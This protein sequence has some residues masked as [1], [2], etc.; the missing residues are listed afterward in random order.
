M[1]KMNWERPQAVPLPE[2]R[3]IYQRMS[4]PGVCR[5][6]R[7]K[8]GYAVVGPTKVM[9][10]GATV[11]V[12]NQK[13]RTLTKV[14]LASVYGENGLGEVVGFPSKDPRMQT[15]WSSGPPAETLEEWKARQTPV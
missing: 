3:P 10:P 12:W 9:H 4:P 15:T 5:W 11:E 14:V 8:G 1:T 2:P 6:T 7:W 13:R